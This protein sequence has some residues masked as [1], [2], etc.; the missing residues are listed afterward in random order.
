MFG[1]LSDVLGTTGFWYIYISLISTIQSYSDVPYV[2][3]ENELQAQTP[4]V[5]RYQKVHSVTF[6]TTSITISAS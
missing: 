4:F 6:G 2:S 3:S 5:T 1:T